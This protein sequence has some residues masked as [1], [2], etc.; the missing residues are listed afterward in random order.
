MPTLEELF[1]K[2]DAISPL[3]LM[4]IANECLDPQ[5]LSTLIFDSEE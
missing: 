3:L 1:A 5:A 4:E 2:I